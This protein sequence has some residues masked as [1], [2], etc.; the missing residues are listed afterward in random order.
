MLDIVKAKTPNGKR[1]KREQSSL[2]ISVSLTIFYYGPISTN[3]F[4]LAQMEKNEG[5][6]NSAE[7]E[8]WLQAAV[9]EKAFEKDDDL[10]HT[11]RYS[12]CKS[13]LR[14]SLL[15]TLGLFPKGWWL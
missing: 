3:G 6:Y 14:I 5:D 12:A 9:V 7:K 8:F 11:L 13:L 4:V 10:D 2:P 1:K 15:P